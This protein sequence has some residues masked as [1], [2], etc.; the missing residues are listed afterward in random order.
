ME[1]KLKNYS[2][3][4]RLVNFYV[5]VPWQKYPFLLSKEV[6]AFLLKGTVREKKCI[7]QIKNLPKINTR[8]RLLKSAEINDGRMRLLCFRMVILISHCLLQAKAQCTKLCERKMRR[9]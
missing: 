3:V 9:Q 6:H 7:S 5:V 8:S 4:H 1:K 2:Q